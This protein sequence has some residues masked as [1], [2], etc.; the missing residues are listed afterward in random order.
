MSPEAS[1]SNLRGRVLVTGAAGML[2]SQLLLDAPEGVVAVGSDLREAP[3]GHPPV[4]LIGHDLTSA[5]A[6]AE[7]FEAAGKLA[8]V[9]HPAAYTAVDKAEEEH[10]LA[11]RVNAEAPGHVAREA[12]QRGIPMVLVSTDFVFDGEGTV[13]YTE[14]DAPNPTSVYGATKLDG[15]RAAA[16]EH[17]GLAIARTQWLYGP[18]G[19]HFPGT[20]LKLAGSHPQLR[21]VDDQRGSPTSTLELSPA[22]W[23]LLGSEAKG[24]FHAACSGEA[25]WYDF[26]RATFELCGVQVQVDPCTTAE[27]PRPAKRPAYSVLDCRRL[28]Q[29]RGGPMAP[30]RDALR[31]FLSKEGLLPA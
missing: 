17:P 23:D 3:P 31:Q 18:R 16:A 19:N 24:V 21:V 5:E 2:G 26:A 10:E 25:S 28:E 27:F 11:A 22:L 13:P 14:D 30:W 12:A 15:E 9:I 20:M 4:E 1:S 8:G 7:L 6:V 29:Q